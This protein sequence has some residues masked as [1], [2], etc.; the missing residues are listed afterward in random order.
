MLFIPILFCGDKLTTLFECQTGK[1]QLTKHILTISLCHIRYI[2]P[3]L[4]FGSVV[5]APCTTK[6][7]CSFIFYTTLTIAA[8]LSWFFLKLVGLNFASANEYWKAT[9]NWNSEWLIYTDLGFVAIGAADAIQWR[10]HASKFKRL[11]AHQSDYSRMM[12]RM[13]QNAVDLL[14]C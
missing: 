13:C 10:H 9:L 3:D 12:I 8:I 1:G 4:V 6:K 14:Y 5:S 2:F 11:R 7:S